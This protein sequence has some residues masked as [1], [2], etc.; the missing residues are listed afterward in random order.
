M[1]LMTNDAWFGH[2]SGPYQHFAQARL[3]AIEQRMPMARVANTGVSGMIDAMGRVTARIGLD[4]MGAVDA[5]L[6]PRGAA[7]AYARWGDAPMLA[8]LL[9]MGLAGMRRNRLDRGR[10]GA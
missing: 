8:L 9:A 10:A 5:A 2:V 1:L 4:E 3:R 7:P 6:P